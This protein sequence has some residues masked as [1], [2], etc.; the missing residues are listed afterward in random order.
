MSDLN[1]I[2]KTCLIVVVISI[3]I[4]ALTTS[5]GIWQENYLAKATHDI[6]D[7]F[8]KDNRLGGFSYNSFGLLSLATM[9]GSG[10]GFFLFK[11]K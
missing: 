9:L 3:M 10:L 4:F 11:D 8:M 7:L 6:T 2:Q 5:N 1:N